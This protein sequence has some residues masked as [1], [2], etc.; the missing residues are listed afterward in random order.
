MFT[1]KNRG[2]ENRPVPDAGV[3][4]KHRCLILPTHEILPTDN[5]R[6][7]YRSSRGGNLSGIQGQHQ[8]RL[9]QLG[10]LGT[11]VQGMVHAHVIRK[12]PLHDAL[13]KLRT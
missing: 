5:Q 8:G 2:Q 9:V 3:S 7:R 11:D 4:E 12:V 10:L 6:M 13:V 1:G